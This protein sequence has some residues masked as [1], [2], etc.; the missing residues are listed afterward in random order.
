LS[1]ALVQIA[2]VVLDVLRFCLAYF[3]IAVLSL[4]PETHNT[5]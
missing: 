1:I 5:V 4:R 3:V 2:A